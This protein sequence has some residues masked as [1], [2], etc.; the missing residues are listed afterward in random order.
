MSEAKAHHAVYAPTELCETEEREVFCLKPFSILDQYSPLDA[1]I[2][3]GDF[4]VSAE[5][6][7]YV[8]LILRFLLLY[9]RFMSSRKISR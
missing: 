9:S 6:W 7:L 1:L 3:L 4:N 2:V 5:S 8:Q